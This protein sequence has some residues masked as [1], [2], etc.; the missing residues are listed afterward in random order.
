MYVN[1]RRT[2]LLLAAVVTLLGTVPGV[3]GA[4]GP[5]E[6]ESALPS[7]AGAERAAAL[8]ELATTLRDA[9]PDKAIAYGTEAVALL[10][11]H[12]L[13][14]REIPLFLALAAACFHRGDMEC[15][16][17]WAEQARAAAEAR[18]DAEGRWRALLEIAEVEKQ[19]GRFDAALDALGVARRIVEDLGDPAKLSRVL[20]HLG[21][22]YQRQGHFSRAMESLLQ[23]LEIQRRLDDP[24]ALAQVL[25]DTARVYESI[26]DYRRSLGYLEEALAITERIGDRRSAAFNRRNLANVQSYLGR[27]DEALDNYLAALAEAEALGD[28]KLRATLLNNVAE[29]LSDVGR[30]DEA[31][32]YAER[33]VPAIRAFGV[34]R[35]TVAVLT[36]YARALTDLG[37]PEEAMPALLEA[38]ALAEKAEFRPVQELLHESFAH[39]YEAMGDYR[40]ALEHHRRFKEIHDELFSED[41][42]KRLAELEA[43]FDAAEKDR[44]IA[45]LEHQRALA[46]VELER[47]K[48]VRNAAVLGSALLLVLAIVVAASYRQKRR[49]HRRLQQ[50]FGRLEATHQALVEQRAE[51]AQERA[52]ADRL[53]EVDRLKDE[54]L[55]NTS[56]ELRTPLQGILGLAES[57]LDGARGELPAPARSDLAMV[58]ASGRR[59]A[60]LVDDILDFS[61]LKHG[62]LTLDRRPVDVKALAEVVIAL[63]RPLVGS[64]DLELLCDLPA[65]LPAADADENRLLQILHNLVGNAIKFTESGSVEV[66]AERRDGALVVRVTDTGIGIAADRRSRIFE[67]FEQADASAE[68][69]FGGTGLGLAVTRQLVELHGGALSVESAVGEGSTFSFTLPISERAAAPPAAPAAPAPPL[70]EQEIEEPGFEETAAGPGTGEDG[71]PAPRILIVDDEPVIR[72]VLA[73]HLAAEGYRLGSASSG[74]EALRLLAEE[75][76]DLVLLDVMMPKMSGYEVCRRLREHHS[77]EE[78]PVVF[79]TAKNRAV[80]L[81]TGLDAGANDYLTKPIAKPE[82]LAR[83]RTH[84]GLLA[85]QRQLVRGIYERQQ[86]VEE[87]EARNAELARFTYTVSHDLKSPLVTIKGFLGLLERDAQDGDLERMRHDIGRI[88]AAADRMRKLLEDLLELSRLGRLLNPPAR[89]ALGEVACEALALVAGDVAARGVEV[90]VDRDL[91]VVVGDRLRL[92]EVFQNLIENAVKYMGEQP[93]PR[94]EVGAGENAGEPVVYVRDN[95]IGIDPLYHDKVFGL[96]ERLDAATEGTGVGLAL[97]KRIVELHGGRIW[98]ESEG[99]G[100]G[101]TFCFSLPPGGVPAAEAEAPRSSGT[102]PP[103]VRGE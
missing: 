96:F 2:A 13:P 68:R 99:V 62:G 81:V 52:V 37:R 70:L 85:A 5:E 40:R 21:N 42:Q 14:E 91:P 10:G 84:L 101:S 49:A 75:P 90:E 72:R 1:Q 11:D 32:A 46:G 63:S 98:V 94:V 103:I 100:R 3:P 60:R 74:A 66:A 53:R 34:D 80:D 67:A 95:G 59:L 47:H 73:N 18:G 86:L 19:R 71:S 78:L 55:A 4:P 25:R 36:T 87:L 58:A 17:A 16:L 35:W 93:E 27:T 92:V 82:L 39:T 44:E 22:V 45:A 6:L 30:H 76:A 102:K 48:A 54:F 33:A 97:V 51:T 43:R 15:Q 24:A 26:E 28:L 88:Q 20:D 79:L 83:V 56:H 69:G 31:L 8:A 65:G 61:K 9:D 41:S 29:L 12:P 77:L 23:A 89:V 38:S 7:L 50:A 64:K 57:L